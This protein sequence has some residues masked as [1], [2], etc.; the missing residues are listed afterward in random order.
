MKKSALDGPPGAPY[1]KRIHVDRC[2]KGMNEFN[3]DVS[4]QFQI[5]LRQK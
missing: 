1:L 2:R 5:Y 4:D 3:T